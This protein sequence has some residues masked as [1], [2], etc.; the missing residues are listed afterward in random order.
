MIISKKLFPWPAPPSP[1]NQGMRKEQASALH[2]RPRVW[3][4]DNDD[5]EARPRDYRDGSPLHLDEPPAQAPHERGCGLTDEELRP[6]S[7]E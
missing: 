2:L 5:D 4:S 3:L 7:K 1:S 6:R